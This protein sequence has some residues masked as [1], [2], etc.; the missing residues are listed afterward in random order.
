[1]A[2][3]FGCFFFQVRLR[4][5]HR[6]GVEALD[7]REDAFKCGAI[8]IQGREEESAYDGSDD[9]SDRPEENSPPRVPIKMRR[10]GISASLPTS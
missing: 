5:D 9:E 8:D 2:R 3:I 4:L 6:I 1:M 10:S 7:W